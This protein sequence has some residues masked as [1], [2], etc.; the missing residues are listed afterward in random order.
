MKSPRHSGSPKGFRGPGFDD[1]LASQQAAKKALL[2]K[3]KAITEKNKEG[4]DERAAER[5]RLADERAKRQAERAEQKRIAAE[6]AAAEKAEAERLAAEEKERLLA[7][8]KARR[9]ERYAK[10]KQKKK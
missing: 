4:A 5:K 10:R 3:A 1:R 9:D 7:E 6:R 2:E 8:Q